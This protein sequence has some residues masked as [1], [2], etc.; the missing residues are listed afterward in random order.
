[1]DFQM[2]SKLLLESESI[3][4]YCVR[5]L[6]SHSAGIFG[7]PGPGRTAE[8]AVPGALGLARAGDTSQT[9]TRQ[10]GLLRAWTAGGGLPGSGGGVVS[11]SHGLWH[12][13]S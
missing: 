3:G 8:G 10:A 6:Y 2:N 5:N 12:P 1:M 9:L 11:V 7:V 4:I 13:G